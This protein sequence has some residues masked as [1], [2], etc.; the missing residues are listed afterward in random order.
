MINTELSRGQPARQPYGA[1]EVYGRRANV[2]PQPEIVFVPQPVPVLDN[3]TPHIRVI[4]RERMDAS[5]PMIALITSI[6]GIVIGFAIESPG[7]IFLGAVAFAWTLL[8]ITTERREP[9]PAIII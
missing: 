2:Q 9:R 8:Q 6:F 4:P 7:V 3:Q 5:L 1:R